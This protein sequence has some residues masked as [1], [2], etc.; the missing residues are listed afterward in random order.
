MTQLEILALQEE[1]LVFERF[2]NADGI[3][4]GS[5]LAKR[6][7]QEGLHA[8]VAV[9]R[10]DG[11]TLFQCAPDGT[12][13][14]NELWMNKKL[15]TVRVFGQSSLRARLQAQETGQTM[16]DHG[17]QDTCAFAP[18][19]FPIRVRNGGVAG[20]AALSGLPG[21]EDHDLLV[22][23]LAEFLG[24]KDLPMLASADPVS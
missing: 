1:L 12:Q 16:A 24:V 18:G 10:C 6:L 21:R 2:T 17:L 11:F 8:T 3:R 14:L 5:F 9:R 20:G 13:P 22:R 23:L 4:L 15:G 7:E 19:G